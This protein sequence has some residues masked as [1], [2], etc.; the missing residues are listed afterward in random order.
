M[1]GAPRSIR[2]RVSRGGN[3]ATSVFVAAA[4]QGPWW[5]AARILGDHDIALIADRV[6]A[7]VFGEQRRRWP[8]RCL[9]LRGRRGTDHAELEE[10]DAPLCIA[11]G[12]DP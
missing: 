3:G 7:D 6:Q 8:G 12:V 11:D 2:Q 4:R 1:P 5:R 9:A 10:A